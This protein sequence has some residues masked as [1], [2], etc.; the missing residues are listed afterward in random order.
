M[1]MTMVVTMYTFLF[2][3]KLAASEAE[4]IL[5]IQVLT[6]TYLSSGHFLVSSETLLQLITAS[7]V[8]YVIFLVVS[9]FMSVCQTM[10]FE[11]LDV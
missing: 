5:I 7:E 1:M 9:V 8:A 4:V 6:S 3:C 2:H 11:S 10:T